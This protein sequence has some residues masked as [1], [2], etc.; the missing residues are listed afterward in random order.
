MEFSR[1]TLL[2]GAVAD[3]FLNPGGEFFIYF[4]TPEFHGTF[5]GVPWP[6]EGFYLLFILL[7]IQKREVPIKLWNLPY[8]SI[9][10]HGVLQC[11]MTF[12]NVLWHST[13]FHNIPQGSVTF[14]HILWCFMTFH[15]IPDSSRVFQ[16][17]PQSSTV[18]PPRPPPHIFS[19][20]AIASPPPSLIS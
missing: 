7:K 11:S 8:C 1:W 12:H 3:T 14:C 17:V 9:L 5:H 16:A 4:C 13:T 20:P 6:S 18:L 19:L 10:F 2:R 15:N